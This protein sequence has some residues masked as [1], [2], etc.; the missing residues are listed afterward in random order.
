MAAALAEL[1][2]TIYLHPADSHLAA[3]PRSNTTQRSL[4]HYAYYPA[5]IAFLAHVISHGALRPPPMPHARP[6]TDGSVLE[7]PGHPQVTH[8]P[9]HT[10]GSCAFEFPEHQVAFV[11]D[12]LCTI[13]PVTG[14]PASPQLQTRGSNTTATRPWPRSAASTTSRA[15]SCSR[16]MEL[17]G[18]RAS[19]QQ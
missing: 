4:I 16:A 6:I 17:P 5:V 2:A 14:R 7:V 12:L 9:G 13:S 1:G 3:R 10:D 15:A 18:A 8:V 19:R 11:G